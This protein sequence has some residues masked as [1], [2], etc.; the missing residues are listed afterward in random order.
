[1]ADRPD[2]IYL[3]SSANEKTWFLWTL[4]V[5]DHVYDELSVWGDVL[6]EIDPT[7]LVN[8]TER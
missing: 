6:M 4:R 7:T 3:L 1:M 5:D 2:E 8:I